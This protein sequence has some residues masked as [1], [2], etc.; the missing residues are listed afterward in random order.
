M[1]IRGSFEIARKQL[2]NFGQTTPATPS[3]PVGPP[4]LSS[5]FDVTEEDRSLEQQSQ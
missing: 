5:V 3:P 4:P 2:E 1:E